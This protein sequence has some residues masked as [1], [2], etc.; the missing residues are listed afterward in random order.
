VPSWQTHDKTPAANVAA[1]LLAKQVFDI[2]F[3]IDH[4]NIGAQ[5]LS[6]LIWLCRHDARQCNDEFCK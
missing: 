3:V 4:E 5:V 1:E 6:P 2:G